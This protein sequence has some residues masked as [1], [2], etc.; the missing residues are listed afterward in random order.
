MKTMTMMDTN[1]ETSGDNLQNA[2]LEIKRNRGQIS[3]NWLEDVSFK[4]D[5]TMKVAHS[6]DDFFKILTINLCW[7]FVLLFLSYFLLWS[8]KV[9]FCNNDRSKKNTKTIR[10]P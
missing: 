4:S 7:E 2:V 10:T 3:S 6:Y 9:M 5:A 1:T 8:S